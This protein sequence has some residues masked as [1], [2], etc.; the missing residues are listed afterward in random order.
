[1]ARQRVH[2]QPSTNSFPTTSTATTTSIPIPTSYS[3]SSV[4]LRR[5]SE[6]KRLLFYDLFFCLYFGPLLLLTF[7]CVYLPYRILSYIIPSTGNGSR[8]VLRQATLSCGGVASVFLLILICNANSPTWSTAFSWS[9]LDH[10]LIGY[11]NTIDRSCGWAQ[12]RILNRELPIHTPLL[13]IPSAL[14]LTPPPL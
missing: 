3:V 4:L 13:S 8:R 5:Y 7:V 2:R 11:E 14:L 12:R 1:M 9:F 6:P 10:I